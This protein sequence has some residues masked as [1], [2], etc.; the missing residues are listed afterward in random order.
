MLPVVYYHCQ[1]SSLLWI[2]SFYE[3]GTIYVFTW[4]QMDIW[5]TSHLGM[6][7]LLS[8]TYLSRSPRKALVP[9]CHV[10]LGSASSWDGD[11]AVLIIFEF[12]H[13]LQA[14]CG[15]SWN[16]KIEETIWYSGDDIRLWIEGQVPAR[17]NQVA[18]NKSNQREIC[19]SFSSKFSRGSFL[20]RTALTWHLQNFPGHTQ[21]FIRKT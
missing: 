7:W 4:M 17:C 12:Q 21:T 5:A 19:L 6:L 20:V 11:E 16:S 15:H 9:L 1:L 13:L 18:P 14:L 2:T 3:Y 10:A 8:H